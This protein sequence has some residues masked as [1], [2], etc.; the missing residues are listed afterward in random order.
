VIFPDLGPRPR[1]SPRS[2]EVLL[3]PAAAALGLLAAYGVLMNP[4]FLKFLLLFPALIFAVAISPERL[5]V[6]W[7][8]F[9]PFVQGASSGHAHGHVFFKFLFFVPPLILVARMATGTLRHRLH[10]SLIDVLPAVYLAYILVRV[11]LFP[12]D[13]S[14]KEASLRGIYGVVG[15]G[16]I[17]YYFVAFGKTSDGF[18]LSVVRTLLWSGIVVAIL[19]LVD[20][21]TGWNL[22]Q[23]TIGG[24]GEVRRVSSTFDG[25]VPLGTYL[26]SATVFGVAAL[27]WKGPRRLQ[28]PAV[29][30]IALAAPALYFTYTRGPILG[31][32]CVGVG[33]ALL[34]NRARWPSLLL[35]AA[36]ALL[37]AVAWNDISSSAIYEKRLGVT[38]TITSRAEIQ[39]ESVELFR[40]KPVF[41]W[42]YN[43]FDEARLTLPDRD[44][45]ISE[46]TSHDTYLTVL[47]ELGAV[48][49]AMLVLPLLLI[50]WRAV[51]ASRRLPAA[52]WILGGCVG[53]VVCY[54]IGAL[55]YDARFFSLTTALPW[56]ALGIARANMRTEQPQL[57]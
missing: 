29:L 35:L 26:G 51:G 37:V 42:G 22:W 15:I 13:L 55:T 56:I 31:T 44:P 18:A 52:R 45:R 36:V 48:G 28:M 7:L 2:A 49:F 30:L 50:C 9:A 40:E 4:P 5:F 34:A 41:G 32:A 43:T 47:V 20:A 27:V 21:A 33:M 17:S 16:I 39:H 46:E 3:Y 11:A 38:S 14:G 57:G 12:T 54:A 6:G 10:V 25:P 23:N 8:F 24:N 1:S 19:A 53:S